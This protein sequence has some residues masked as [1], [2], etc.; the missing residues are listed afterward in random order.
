MYK[1]YKLKKRNRK[2][3]NVYLIFFTLMVVCITIAYAYAN[4]SDI[5]TII[6]RANLVPPCKSTYVWEFTNNNYE[7]WGQGT[8]ANPRTYQPIIT[9]TN[10]D[11]E[12]SGWTVSFEVED[13]VVPDSV[14]TWTNTASVSG[15]TVTIG[16][17]Y[18]ETIKDNDTIVLNFQIQFTN[19]IPFVIKN[20]RLNGKLVT[21]L[22][23]PDNGDKPDENIIENTIVNNE[24]TNTVT[25][26]ITNSTG[27]GTT[28]QELIPTVTIGEPAD[29][30]TTATQITIQIKNNTKTTKTLKSFYLN[31]SGNSAIIDS[32]SGIDGKSAQATKVEDNKYLVTITNGGWANEIKK[33]KSQTYTVIVRSDINLSQV[34]VSNI[35]SE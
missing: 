5:L 11:G 8:L 3:T 25:N 30:G 10:K 16:S 35:E 7:G 6:G 19:K 26:T 17:L 34:T 32:V 21:C 9:I 31:F 13:G 15:N 28:T 24:I 14:T 1:K 33:K 29:W 20:L 22:G 12:L 4:Y 27:G 2:R 18:D 23:S